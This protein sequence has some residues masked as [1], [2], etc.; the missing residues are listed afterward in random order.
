[1]IKGAAVPEEQADALGPRV[2]A[3]DWVLAD[4]PNRTAVPHLGRRL[5]DRRADELAQAIADRA[6]RGGLSSR[7]RSDRIAAID[8]FRLGFLHSESPVFITGSGAVL[9]PS[10]T[11]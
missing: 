11:P 2:V 9:L 4:E 7:V 10:I 3:D 8:G 6:S 1:L 5:Q